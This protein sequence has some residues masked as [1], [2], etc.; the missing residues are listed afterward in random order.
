MDL[1]SEKTKSAAGSQSRAR[2]L[3]QREL[4]RRCKEKPG[5]SLRAFARFLDMDPTAL[6]RILSGKRRVTKGVLK[7]ITP[8][9]GLDP[10]TVSHLANEQVESSKEQ[11]YIQISQDTFEAIGNWYYL[12]ILEM[13]HLKGF[14]GDYD[15]IARS[16]GITKT[17]VAI[18]VET[19]DRLG[20]LTINPD[21]T[22]A[23][24]FDKMESLPDSFTSAGQRAFQAQVLNKAIDALNNLPLTAR[25]QT[26]ITFA[27][28][29]N[30]LPEA[31]KMLKKFRREVN[32]FMQ[33]SN[34]C[35]TVY[36]MT[37]SLFPV[38]ETLVK[39]NNSKGKT[40]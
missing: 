27:A 34:Q 38:T 20:M 12:A 7:K 40:K 22:W 26:A 10:L 37:V 9:L 17:E 35:D 33:R 29:S 19:L 32:R 30:S 4:M 31:K 36:V 18:A 28:D 13:T 2:L 23:D 6:S 11:E 21:G 8:K 14:K 3:L 15:W 39:P 24:H 1:T 25:D 16:L 5:Y